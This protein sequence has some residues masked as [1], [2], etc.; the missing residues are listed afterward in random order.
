MNRQN[1]FLKDVF[2]VPQTFLPDRGFQALQLIL[3]PQQS[4]DLLFPSFQF[5]SLTHPRF[6]SPEQCRLPVHPVQDESADC[7]E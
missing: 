1:R 5:Q 2:Q 3:R 6:R 7:L 4:L